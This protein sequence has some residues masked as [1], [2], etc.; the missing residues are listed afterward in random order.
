VLKW[1]GGRPYSYRS[2]RRGG[3]VVTEYRGKGPAAILAEA[4]AVKDRAFRRR[5]RRAERRVVRSAVARLEAVGR[6]VTNVSDRII[7]HFRDA[8]HICGWYVHCWSWRKRGANVANAAW[9]QKVLEDARQAERAKRLF[10]KA[11]DVPALV[12][13]LGGGLAER[14]RQKLIEKLSPTPEVRE[15]FRREAEVLR[16]ALEGENPTVIEHLV[17]ERIIIS[18][19]HVSWLDLLAFGPPG[20]FI[21]R[22]VEVHV[23]RL[24]GRAHR[25]YLAA[26]KCLSLIRKAAPAA[27]TVNINKTVNVD[28]KP[29]GPP[30]N[31][32]P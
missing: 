30:G 32:K 22:E 7:I 25:D 10:E 3:R 2:V 13:K 11:D 4:A 5:L 24:R 19:L 23:A 31:G 8:M 12:A 9:D 26:I 18:W 16:R 21:Q 20:E 1:L 15:V 29:K 14:V 17:V 6:V 27:V 28:K